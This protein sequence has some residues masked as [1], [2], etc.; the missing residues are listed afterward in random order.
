MTFKEWVESQNVRA[1][2]DHNQNFVAC[3][4]HELAYNA[5]YDAGR[6]EAREPMD[7]GH[8]KACQVHDVVFGAE[9]AHAVPI[10]VG[11]KC[12]VCE[13]KPRNEEREIF[14]PSDT[15]WECESGVVARWP[16]PLRTRA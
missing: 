12:S 4:R 14:D 2:M 5:G 8:P 15:S 16:C 13:V 6:V 10:P 3:R 7:C 1:L 9:D 11:E